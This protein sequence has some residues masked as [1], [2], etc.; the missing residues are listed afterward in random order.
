[1]EALDEAHETHGGGDGEH[2]FVHRAAL[3]VHWQ[4]VGHLEREMSLFVCRGWGWGV[5]CRMCVWER[6]MLV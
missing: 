6:G 1:M 4:A 2:D 3:D 5:E